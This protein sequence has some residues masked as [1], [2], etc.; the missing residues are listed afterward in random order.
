M[1]K[2]LTIITG[3]TLL[4]GLSALTVN[5]SPIVASDDF[6][7]INF[8]GGTGW[9]GNWTTGFTAQTNSSYSV[10]GLG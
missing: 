7:S 5:A 4:S 9:T 8:S 2:I 1:K 10:S 6:K 3:L